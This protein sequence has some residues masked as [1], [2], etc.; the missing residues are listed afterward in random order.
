MPAFWTRDEATKNYTSVI[1][2]FTVQLISIFSLAMIWKTFNQPIELPV[3]HRHHVCNWWYCDALPKAVSPQQPIQSFVGNRPV[4]E[5]IC[6]SAQ[7]ETGTVEAVFPSRYTRSCLSTSSWRGNETEEFENQRH[8]ISM[9]DALD[10]I[11]GSRAR[12]QVPIPGVPEAVEE[13]SELWAV[14]CSVW[15]QRMKLWIVT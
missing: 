7:T 2:H 5:H 1:I 3:P 6:G 9:R 13:A 12:L 15:R 10:T 11:G 14:S 4:E 8:T